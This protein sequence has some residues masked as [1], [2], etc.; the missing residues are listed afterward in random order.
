MS[1]KTLLEIALA[2]AMAS[3]AGDARADGDGLTLG[4]AMRRAIAHNP[5]LA[6]AVVDVQVADAR[7]TEA[8]GLDDFVLGAGVTWSRSRGPNAAA[9][10]T[11]TTPYDAVDASASLTRPLSTGGSVA[12]KL[13]APWARIGAASST[14]GV[15]TL[16]VYQP[17]AQIVATQP[18]LRGRGYDVARAPLRLANVN[19]GVAS[20]DLEARATTL[21]RDVARAYWELA[22]A[23]GAVTEHRSALDAA[24]AQLAAVNAQIAVGKAP[25]SASA[26]VEVSVALREDESVDAD[27]ALAQ[28]AADLG[29]LLGMP[30][31]LAAAS[32]RAT[33]RPQLF[34][35]P[36]Q[37]D[38]VAQALA[39]NPEIA[40]L[41]A[42]ADA[43]RIGVDVADSRLL[44]LLDVTASAGPVG[45]ASDP[46]PALRSLSTL[47]GFTASAGV[48]FEEPI[49]RRAAKGALEAARGGVQ[50]ASLAEVDAR[51][52]VATD[53]ANAATALDASRRRVALLTRATQVAE[54]DLEGE[55]AR[56][57]ANRST[58]FDVLRRQQALA[59]TRLRLLRAQ[60][61]HAEAMLAIDALSG[62]LLA[63]HGLAM[64]GIGNAEEHR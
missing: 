22:F 8:R 44:P 40:S 5:T 52:R 6:S 9:Q 2:V 17:S 50:K 61:D 64:R 19:R 31:D 12:L 15:G 4:D 43:F 16:D 45:V 54:L 41:H 63:R 53:V 57:Q 21:A 30:R 60:A 24:R 25:P 26:E 56:F 29:R 49:E 13:D 34:E 27:A 20:L 23:A 42:R 58:S 59:D 51:A 62:D 38:A 7:V 48:V 46:S 55:T 11:P 18:L 37:D 47:S 33:E 1:E 36:V 32:L 35:Q 3:A 39:R 14:G 28:R 10:S